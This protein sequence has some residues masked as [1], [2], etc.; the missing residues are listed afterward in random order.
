[1]SAIYSDPPFRRGTTLLAGEQI[2]LNAAG[3]PIA[4]S[5]IVG[6]VKAFQ[7]VN[8]VGRGERY[9]NRLVY[10]VA[11]RYTGATVANAA[12]VA[13]LAYVF[14]SANP[15]SE[16]S[17]LA[18]NNDVQAQS[19]IGILDEYL[20]GELRTNDVVWLVV[21]GPT[22]VQKASGNPVAPLGRVEIGTGQYA[23]QAHPLNIGTAAAVSI[24][25]TTV[26]GTQGTLLRIHQR[27]EWF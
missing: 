20:R 23:G 15:L 3:E 12:T 24:A 5:E 25:G 11:A 8:P 1:M 6:Q 10:C 27:F 4:G 17:A 19:P 9:S 7:D 21:G 14:D 18:T 13:G 16:F 26:G 2:E 22:S